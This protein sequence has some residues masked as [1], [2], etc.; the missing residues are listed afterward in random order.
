MAQLEDKLAFFDKTHKEYDKVS[1][2]VIKNREIVGP[3]ELALEL[4]SKEYD[5]QDEIAIMKSKVEMAK[6]SEQDLMVVNTVLRNKIV[7]LQAQLAMP[8]KNLGEVLDK[9]LKKLMLYFIEVQKKI[10][11]GEEDSES[12]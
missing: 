5:W 1:G 6:K 12:D 10:I 4:K 3:Q 7:S 11:T 9:S 2:F 8:N